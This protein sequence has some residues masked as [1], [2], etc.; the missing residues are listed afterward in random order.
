ML[1]FHVL[2]VLTYTEGTKKVS[3]ILQVFQ[4]CSGPAVIELALTLCFYR[5]APCCFWAPSFALTFKCPAHCSLSYVVVVLT[6]RM[7][8]PS[9]SSLGDNGANINPP[10][11]FALGAGRW[12]FSEILRIFRKLYM[13]GRTLVLTNHI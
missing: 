13:C 2:K 12:R 7:S 11:W 10:V 9:P 1:R 8:N 3:P 4:W 5:S 6:K